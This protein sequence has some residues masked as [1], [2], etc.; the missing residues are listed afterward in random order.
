[1]E[2]GVR[3]EAFFRAGASLPAAFLATRCH[4]NLSVNVSER[5]EADGLPQAR[6]QETIPGFLVSFALL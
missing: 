1:M 3:F 4:R 6:A 2:G 5:V